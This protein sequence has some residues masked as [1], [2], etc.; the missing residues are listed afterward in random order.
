MPLTPTELLARIRGYM[1]DLFRNDTEYIM[2]DEQ[3]LEVYQDSSST[4]GGNTILTARQC[5]LR[6]ATSSRSNFTDSTLADAMHDRAQQLL[7][8]NDERVRLEIE[9]D[10]ADDIVVP[11]PVEDAV[12]LSNAVPTKVGETG[13]A[14]GT[15]AKAAREGHKHE[16]TTDVKNQLDAAETHINDSSMHG[17]GMGGGDVTVSLSLM[18]LKQK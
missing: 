5:C 11:M 2:S 8:E 14:P 18:P 3:I 16:L 12:T 4:W 13:Q 7:D 10:S 6:V 9:Q 1:G 15:V 17:A